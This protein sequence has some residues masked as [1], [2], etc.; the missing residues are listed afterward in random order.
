[1]TSEF[2]APARTTLRNHNV[3]I[4]A[5]AL[6]TAALAAPAAQARSAPGAYAEVNG[7]KLYY[8][9]H[10]RNSGGA[11]PLVMIHGAFGTIDNCFGKL[12]PR[13]A[14][15]RQ[16]I[17][18]ELQGHGRTAD[19]DRPLRYE[20][21]ADDVAALLK[22]IKV[23]TA[24]VHGY[25][26]GGAVALQVAI[27]HPEVVR[28]LVV[29]SATFDS[30][31]WQPGLL[32]MMKGL[33]PEHL[34]GSP[35]ARDYARVAPRPGNWGKLVDKVRELD[36]LPQQWPSK[37]IQAIK[38]PTLMI[39]GDSDAVTAEHAVQ[40]YRLRGG[41]GMGDLVGL[42]DSQLAILPGTHHVGV[43]ERVDLLAEMIPAFL[44]APVKKKR[45]AAAK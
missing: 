42:P 36:S 38:A 21:L 11:P 22:Q 44:D 8:E 45:V 12:I 31:G 26:M 16:V 2:S 18:V 20:Q 40:I 32:D 14:K 28:K 10:G 39:A 13:L 9:V 1:M 34:A 25:S 33:T 43:L 29:A 24:D 27:R 4:L 15:R 6:V 5:T 23:P 17:G 37:D 19:I 3:S 7:L 35:W 41:G 30:T